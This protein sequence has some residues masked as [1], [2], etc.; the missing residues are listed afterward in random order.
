MKVPPEEA[1]SAVADEANA[2]SQVTPSH[3]PARPSDRRA[4]SQEPRSANGRTDGR[5][6]LSGRVRTRGANLLSLH[7]VSVM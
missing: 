3:D 7:Y 1:D 4:V 2:L 6:L 5:V